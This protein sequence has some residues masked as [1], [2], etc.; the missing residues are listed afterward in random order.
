MG[1]R[2]TL[3]ELLHDCAQRFGDRPFLTIAPS[4]ETLSYAEM[5]RLTNRLGHGL[6]ETFGPGLGHLAIMLENSIP[7]MAMSYALK[8]LDVIEVSINRAFRGPALSRMINLTECSV[9]M[10]SKAHFDTLEAVL[11]ELP[12]LLAL[13]VTDDVEATAQ[14]FPKLR[15]FGYEPLL[16]NQDSHIVCTAPDTATAAIMFTS[17]TTGVSKG[18]RLSHRFAV[19][20]AEHMIAPFRLISEDANYTPYPLSHIGPAYYDILPMMLIGGRAILRDG[21]SLSNFWPE[22]ARFGATWFICLGS[23]QQ[24]LYSAPPCPEERQH[25]VT[26]CWATPA[27][28]PK[29][30]FDARFGL[31]LIPGG[32]YGSTDAGWM[33]V[34]QW[35]HPGGQVLP[36]FEVAI[37]DD[38]DEPL[39]P[40]RD[41]EIVI[42]PREPGVMSDEY[43]GMPDKTME[44]RRNL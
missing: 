41:G 11:D 14:R 6:L 12:H 34:P 31:H 43:V 39:P 10:T 3:G 44:S 27:P 29:A 25:R 26:R 20:T 8:K 30:E 4:G 13:I 23:V 2:I 18:C 33:V 28:V 37:V 16:S 1:L 38:N 21:F 5:E 36:H 15:V 7:Y 17:G 24:L 40:G 19:R 9:L 22:V 42:R 32:G 35:D